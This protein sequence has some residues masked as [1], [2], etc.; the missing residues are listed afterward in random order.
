MIQLITKYFRFQ[1]SKRMLD[2]KRIN[3]SIALIIVSIHRKRWNKINKKVYLKYNNSKIILIGL[4]IK[5][6]LERLIK[7]HSIIIL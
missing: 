2:L 7:M 5:N 1:K 4:K 3:N 6:Y